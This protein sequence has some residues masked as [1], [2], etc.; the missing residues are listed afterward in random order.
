[1]ML[2]HSRLYGSTLVFV[3]GLFSSPAVFSAERYIVDDEQSFVRIA[4]KMCEPDLLKGEF[5]RVS[6]EILLDEQN[7]ENSSVT[8][9]VTA[10]NAFF[11]HEF[12][13]TDNIKDIV[14]G[15]KIL[16]TL[17]FPLITFKS[18]EII[19][20]NAQQFQA[21][22]EQSSV[23]TAIVKGDLTLVGVTHPFEMEVT[24]H[25]KTGLTSKGRLVAAFSTFGTFKRSD[26]GVVYGLDRVGIRRMGD[27]VMVMTSITA[28]RSQ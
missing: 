3:C 20:T 22:G 4:A 17:K 15:E 12:H 7:L 19:L 14:M 11:D 8:I 2:K 27:E 26:F 13:R 23:I 24:F 25:E 16:N 28:N 9:T 21:Y 10:A 5:G 1:M 18:T 6:G